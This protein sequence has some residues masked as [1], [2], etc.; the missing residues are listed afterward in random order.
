MSASQL[1]TARP[2][3]PRAG[4]QAGDTSLVLGRYRLLRRLGTGGFGTVWMGHDERLDRDVAVKVLPRE[5]VVGGRFEREARVAARLTHPGIVTLYEATVDDD[6]AYLVSELVRGATLGELLE[7]GRLSD[8]DIAGVAIGLCDALAH[9]H[10]HGVVHRDVKPSNVLIPEQPTSRAHPA[11]LTDFGVA[12]VIGGDSLTRTGDIIGTAAYMAPEQAEGRDAGPAA[13]LYA[14]ALVTYEALTG[15]N[16]IR[17]NTAAV[18]ARRLGAHLPPLRRQRRDLPRELGRGVDLALRPRARER[19]SLDELRTALVSALPELADEPGVV[20]TAWPRPTSH[21]RDEPGRDAGGHTDESAA[22]LPECDDDALA[23]GGDAP[24]SLSWPQRGLGAVGAAIGVGW[25]AAHVLGTLPV[26]PPAL[27]VL[28]F[29]LVLT[30]PRIGW[31]A[32]GVVLVAA[33]AAEHNPGAALVLLIALVLPMVLIPWRGTS[34]PV[35][36]AAPVLGAVG[37]A[38]AWPALA[39]RASGFGWRRAALG[40]IGYVWVLVA[41]LILGTD[42]YMRRPPGT[43]APD[44]WMSSLSVTVNDVLVPVL[45]SGVLLGAPVWGI[46]AAALPWVLRG[47]SLASCCVITTVWSAVLV[48]ATETVVAAVHRGHGLGAPRG[49]VIGAVAGGLIA[50]APALYAHVRLTRFSGNPQPELP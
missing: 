50:L 34:W 15:I 27:G 49:A 36:V 43:A 5:R 1:P 29:L 47:R 3:T 17:T 9:A 39:G 6:G 44:A 25:A 30:L 37:L 33:A 42:L 26:A 35:G 28:A 38:G 46:A 21:P 18:R 40:V 2:Q 24:V 23:V 22:P 12:R 32:S 20:L 16:P 4:A 19:G 48:S 14:V 8:R 13:D 11:K 41:S 45:K 7:A 31:V 10:A